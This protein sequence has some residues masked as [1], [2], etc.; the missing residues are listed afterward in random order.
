MTDPLRPFADMIRALWLARTQGVSPTSRSTTVGK[1]RTDAPPPRGAHSL[2]SQLKARVCASRAAGPARMREAF[3][4]AVLLWELGEQLAPDPAFGEM[5]TSVS[6][7]LASDPTVG[8]RLNR[9]LARLAADP[10]A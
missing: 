6:E 7:Q 8:E 10:R 9:A 5:V 1:A 2:R 4:E 3:V